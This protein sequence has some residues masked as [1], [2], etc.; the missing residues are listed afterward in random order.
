MII[1]DLFLLTLMK[2]A[3]FKA[4]GVIGKIGSRLKSN[5]HN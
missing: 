4:A 5:A 3:Y 2:A 1:F